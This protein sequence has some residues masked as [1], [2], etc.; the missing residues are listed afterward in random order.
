[1]SC[2]WW[3]WKALNECM[4]CIRPHASISERESQSSNSINS[5]SRDKEIQEMR[6]RSEREMDVWVGAGR[7]RLWV[8]WECFNNNNSSVC[9]SVCVCMCVCVCVWV[10]VCV[11]GRG[12]V[13]AYKSDEIT[14]LLHSTAAVAIVVLPRYLDFSLSL[15]RFL[16]LSL[17]LSLSVSLSLFKCINTDQWG[18]SASIVW[19]TWLSSLEQLV[20][21]TLPIY[22]TFLTWIG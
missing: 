18:K 16:S 14:S 15:S 4:Q 10:N 5:S 19:Y 12:G 21:C 2:L 9:V 8:S 1:M 11:G 6:G 22:M 3:K 7:R 17:S 20:L 13:I